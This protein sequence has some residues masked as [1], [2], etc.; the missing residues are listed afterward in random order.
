MLQSVTSLFIV[1]YFF[2]ATIILFVQHGIGTQW[3]K[4]IVLPRYNE[5]LNAK[6]RGVL[7][8]NMVITSAM[9]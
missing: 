1:S 7:Y 9:S 8:N 6:Q 2:L 3:G 5:S 4:K